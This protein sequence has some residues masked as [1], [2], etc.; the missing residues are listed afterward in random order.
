MAALPLH[1][2]LF[3]D[4]ETVP[5]SPSYID[6]SDDWKKLWDTKSTSL[7]KYHEGQTNETLYPR[8]GIY[9]EFGKIVC[10]SCGVI[11]GNGEQRKIILKSF[12]G[13]DEKKLL[14][15]F[16]DMLN[17]WATGEAKFLCA[18]NGKEFDF[19][20]L[21][22]RMIIHGIT[23]PSLLNISG[24][25]PWEVNHYD[26]LELWKFGDYK[27]FTSLN[28]LAHVLGVPTPKDDI[29]GS[30]VWEVY[31]KEKNL[32][33]IVTYCQKDVVTVAQILLR[34][35]GEQLIK[36]ENIEIKG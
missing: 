13:D 34:M 26:T 19:P 10:I 14:V 6:L 5:Q 27:S 9:A 33:R 15:D 18:H 31:W 12:Y 11:Q 36:E 25:K 2:I 16:I 23:I 7:V 29:D 21:C 3:L 28:L 1:N 20:Y 30:M 4:I 8:A 32:E 17:K 35:N 22:R 24:K